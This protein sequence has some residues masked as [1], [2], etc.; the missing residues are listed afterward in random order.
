MQRSMWHV[1]LVVALILISLPSLTACVGGEDPPPTKV[2]L[3][4][5]VAPENQPLEP[6]IQDFA[7]SARARIDITYKGSV[8]IM[9][10]LG[11]GVDSS[12]D[13]AWPD[14]SLWIQLGDSTG[15]VK[16]ATSMMRSPVVFGVRTSVAE[17]LGWIGADVTVDDILTASESGKLRVMMAS[18]TQ[19]DSGASAYLGFLYAFAGHPSVLQSADL[20][21]PDVQAQTKRI[22]GAMSRT[23][24]NAGF[25]KDLFLQ[26]ED[27]F[28][29]IVT[30]EATVIETNQVLVQSGRE[31][32][33]AIYP[34]D[35][36]AIAD[37]P[38]ALIDKHDA[39]KNAL[40]LDLQRRLLSDDVQRQLLARGRRTGLGINPAPELVDRGIFNPAWGI[41]TQRVLAP[42]RMPDAP[43]VLEALNLYQTTFRKPSLT[44]YVLDYSTSMGNNGGEKQ[45]KAAMHLLLDQDSAARYLLQASPDDVTVVIPFAGKV[46]G[47]W[48][49]DG[50]DDAAMSALDQKISDGKLH[51]GTAIYAAVLAAL[52]VVDTVGSSGAYPSIVL[53]TDGQNNTGATLDDVRTKVGL[54]GSAAVPIFTITFGDAR[55][56][57]VTPLADLTSG[58]VFD[59]HE[60]LAGAF[61]QAKGFN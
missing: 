30:Y 32:L 46:L 19:S 37:A 11:K 26:Q 52:A 16:Y 20:H 23:A 10:E 51:D 45:M 50:N 1:P 24:G 34:R 38:L 57:D 27:Q 13:A 58:A 12:Y 59:G 43:V 61:R 4:I 8:E 15:A 2:G 41:D 7:T 35:A 6:L 33:Y 53:M 54:P 21:D 25:L 22:L 5:L 28:D 17:R 29:A 55:L 42:I 49:A 47:Q 14:N 3:R 39:K 40:F 60:D 9:G 31:P 48:E 56:K 44:V 18:A 36:T